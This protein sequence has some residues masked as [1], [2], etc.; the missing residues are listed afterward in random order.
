MAWFQ[1]AM[2]G[3]TLPLIENR[4]CS[5]GNKRGVQK[6]S[7]TTPLVF[8]AEGVCL[9]PQPYGVMHAAGMV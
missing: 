5:F 7:L 3:A 4:Q 8:Q 2:G 9:T 1:R 6:D